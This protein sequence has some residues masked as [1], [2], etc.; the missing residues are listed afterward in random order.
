MTRGYGG[1]MAVTEERVDANRG[2]GVG[3]E[4]TQPSRCRCKVPED[5]GSLP[6][7]EAQHY[8]HRG[9]HCRRLSDWTGA[10]GL[11]IIKT[12]SRDRRTVQKSNKD[13][14]DRGARVVAERDSGW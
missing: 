14:V 12:Q 13:G 1:E 2:A 10:R 9:E 11:G 4:P 8:R 6:E 7:A 5:R 3:T